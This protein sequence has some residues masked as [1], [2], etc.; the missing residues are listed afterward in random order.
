MLE[1]SKLLALVTFLACAP[2]R[3]ATRDGLVDLLW[4][5]LDPDA[6][7]HAV[8]QHLWQLRRKVGAELVV[9]GR[10][11]LVM[12][13]VLDS[14]RARY[15]AASESGDFARAVE[16]YAGEFF[17][18][19]AASGANEFERWV[20]R[21][22]WELRS[23]FVRCAEVVVRD[24]LNAHHARDAVALARR[25]RDAEPLRQHGW[26]ILLEALLASDDPVSAAVE[27]DSL[28]R[29]LEQEEAVLEPATKGIVSIVRRAG[30]APGNAGNPLVLHA[31][32]VGREREFSELMRAWE[33][34]KSGRFTQVAIT[35]QAGLG[36]T[37]LLT[38]FHARLQSVRARCVFVRGNPGA[39]T[40]PFALVADLAER[41][42]HLA[43]ARGVSPQSGQILVALSPSLSSAFAVA[44]M[45]SPPADAMRHRLSA[46]RELITAVAAERPLA[47]LVDDLHWSDAASRTVLDGLAGGLADVG[48]LLCVASRS[49]EFSLGGTGAARVVE[50]EPLSEPSVLS[51]V[52]SVATLPAAPWAD[53]LI[54]E[55]TQRTRGVPLYVIESLQLALQERLLMIHDGEWKCP[56]ADRLWHLLA[57][58]GVL[59]RRL[60]HLDESE[61]DVLRVIAAAATP[62]EPQ[63]VLAAAAIGAYAGL[64]AI[65]SLQAKGLLTTGPG[66]VRVAH[67]EL[68]TVIE[69]ELS[70]DERR[71]IDEALGTTLGRGGGDVRQMQTAA[72]FLVRAGA[73]PAL[74][75]LFA[76]FVADARRRRDPRRARALAAELLG[77]G[78]STNAVRSIARSLPFP[79]RLGTGVRVVA[80]VA[81]AALLLIGASLGVW[82]SRSFR[83]EIPDARLHAWVN[84]MDGRQRLLEV[85]LRSAAWNPAQAIRL[86]G[87]SRLL[88]E[89]DSQ[90]AGP[91]LRSPSAPDQWVGSRI[92]LDSGVTDL[93][94]I[95]ERGARVER[96][97]FAVGDDVEPSWSPDGRFVVF[98]T[99]RWKT[100]GERDLA[101]LD[102]V[103]RT[104]TRLTHAGG[105]DVNPL[106]SPDGTRIAFTR[107]MDGARRTLCVTE[108]RL[109]VPTCVGSSDQTLIHAQAWDSDSSLVGIGSTSSRS[110]AARVLLGPHRVVWMDSG[111]ATS[112]VSDDAR[113][114]AG[115]CGAVVRA[116]ERCVWRRGERASQRAVHTDSTQALRDLHFADS[117]KDFV[118][119][120]EVLGI[121]ATPPVGVPF[122]LSVMARTRSGQSARP[123]AVGFRSFDETTLRVDDHGQLVGLRPGTVTLEVSA[124]GWRADTVR[125]TVIAPPDTTAVVERW[126]GLAERWV[127]FGDPE[128]LVTEGAPGDSALLVNGDGTFHS[129]V[130]SR[131]VFDP[132]AG[133]SMRVRMSAP[134]TQRT[135]QQL[136]ASL[137][138]NVNER[139]LGSWDG[140]AGYLWS[141]AW[142]GTTARICGLTYPRPD[143]SHA[144]RGLLMIDGLAGGHPAVP[145]PPQVQNGAWFTLTVQL[146]PDGRCGIAVDDV[147][148]ALTR[149]A[150]LSLRSVRVA[151]YGNSVGT[152]ILVG[153]VEIRRGVHPG[154]DWS[155]VDPP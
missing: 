141:V 148:V 145:A 135:W 120:L 38:A 131:T 117:P 92:T 97:T 114:A 94:L 76:K 152:R 56:E 1:P 72:T 126:R 32:L 136:H 150:H 5:D 146:L 9:E 91:P 139:A 43:G 46:V 112:F 23:R 54:P 22:R 143:E 82:V 149:E 26:R 103:T 6:G 87:R 19:F 124:G 77:D 119:S 63:D 30:P 3:T 37:R 95:S 108:A 79:V 123:R 49:L 86:D 137:L 83:A 144:S 128:P 66:G 78:A 55:L 59:H 34:A 100:N 50:L 140:R 35:A 62:M 47:I 121:Q 67:D 40:V 7:R 11:Q 130:L 16:L 107:Q 125:L 2:G 93:Y 13:T 44:P 42:G 80:L 71:R 81:G 104:T 147:P 24:L 69:G 25:I 39:T 133:V 64:A 142:S 90:W 14:D 33:R 89:L 99:A 85:P 70:P 10:D 51:L 36:K 60:Q 109:A 101:I 65:A 29:L 17:P 96:L 15:I 115:A 105:N 21:E 20:D 111:P 98:S 8:R 45:V 106:W 127:S 27:A 18:G 31:E 41:L 154:I 155:A 102:L 75:A 68:A 48:V 129:G 132:A 28:E 134:I 12:R 57:T 53:R 52:S 151:F 58:G 122:V 84:D 118:Q 153:R 73:Y 113:W 74:E 138:V 110:A 4:A 61:F 88:L 116:G